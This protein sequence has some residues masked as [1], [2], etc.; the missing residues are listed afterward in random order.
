LL[1]FLGGK[2][3]NYLAEE[4]G[5]TI[6]C[7]SEKQKTDEVFLKKIT[8]LKNLYKETRIIDYK[9]LIDCYFFM[10]FLD[11]NDYKIPTF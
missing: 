9:W 5:N 6:Y 2:I 3:I 7:I 4:N 10:S 8:D 11:F 1:K